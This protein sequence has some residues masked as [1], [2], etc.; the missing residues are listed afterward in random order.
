MSGAIVDIEFRRSA[1]YVS[2]RVLRKTTAVQISM[3]V[4]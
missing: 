4:G 3:I 2:I 1:L